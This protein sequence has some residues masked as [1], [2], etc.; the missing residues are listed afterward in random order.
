MDVPIPRKP[1][2]NESEEWR[3]RKEFLE[4]IKAS[5]FHMVPPPPPLGM[6][7]KE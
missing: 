4:Q 7:N 5:P 2:S 1:T 3:L 6:K